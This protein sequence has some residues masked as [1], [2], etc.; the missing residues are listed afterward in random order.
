M[1]IR[2]IADVQKQFDTRGIAIQH[3]G[4]KDVHLPFLIKK[5]G[6]TYES[7]LAKIRFT[8]ALPEKYKGTHMSRFMEILMP[9]SQKPLAESEIQMMLDEAMDKLDAQESEIEISFKY[10]VDKEA[11]VSHKKSLL[12]YDAS[13]IAEKQREKKMRFTLGLS[14][15]FTS[16]C[17]CSKAISDYGAHNQRSVCRVKVRFRE[18]KECIY[19][20]DLASLIEAQASAP[21]FPLLKREDEKYVT[22]E[23]YDHPKFVEDILRDCVIALRKLDGISWFSLECENYESI[24]NHNACASHEETVLDE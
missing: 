1:V 5:K 14:V 10:F 3:V 6:G 19:I 12:D 7:V 20:E 24:H 2:N 17:P 15:P 4:V 22:E 9:W 21:I 13:F 18:G 11:P 23:A 8:V 16:L